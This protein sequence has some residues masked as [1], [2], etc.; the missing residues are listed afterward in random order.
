MG[1][2]SLPS[3]DLYFQLGIKNLLGYVGI[4]RKHAVNL[5]GIGW[6]NHLAASIQWNKPVEKNLRIHRDGRMDFLYLI[7]PLLELMMDKFPRAWIPG[8]MLTVDESLWS[9]KGRTFLKRFMKDKPKKYGFLEYALCTLNGYFLHVLVHHLPGKKKRQKRNLN[10][11]NLDRESLNQ[12]RLQGRYGEQGAILMRL[13]SRLKYAGH[14]IVGDN[15]FS[16]I[17][18]ATDLK[19]GW[20]AGNLR[21]VACDYT[22]TQVMPKKSSSNLPFLECK[23]LP[24]DGWPLGLRNTIMIGILIMKRVSV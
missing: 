10:E 21:I 11:D 4:D 9:L 24:L 6:Y 22:G 16:S 18:L 3:V 1:L 19:R 14:H 20:C 17:Q 8:T 23:N 2:V 5:P 13:V 15:A 12:L 7:R